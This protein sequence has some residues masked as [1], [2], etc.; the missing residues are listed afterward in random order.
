MEGSGKMVI[1]AVGVNSQTGIIMT[2]LNSAN[3]TSSTPSGQNTQHT[4]Q[5]E[6]S[7]FF[8]NCFFKFILAL[9]VNGIDVNGKNNL[10]NQN[11][12]L[13]V[14]K[15]NSISNKNAPIL[16]SN[17]ND[18]DNISKTKSVL[19][20]KLS[21]LAIRIGFI[22]SIVAAATVIVLIVRYCIEEYLLENRS[23]ER[24]NINKFVGFIINGVTILV[25][26]VPEGLPLA[27]TLALS[28]SVKKV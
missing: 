14:V 2:F 10:Q 4:I 23:F 27:I 1:T 11:N 6:T 12:Q 16:T 9:S 3:S 13:K 20:G 25:I 15:N 8:K 19:Q 26:A 28:Y 17:T 5:S 24:S 7:N 21:N 22:G 18:F